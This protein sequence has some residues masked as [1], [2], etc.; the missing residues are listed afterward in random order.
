MADGHLQYIFSFSD[1]TGITQENV[2]SAGMLA[3]NFS[4]PTIRMRSVLKSSAWQ[5]FRQKRSSVGVIRKI[6]QR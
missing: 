5:R 4:A 6:V 2:M 1:V 3:A